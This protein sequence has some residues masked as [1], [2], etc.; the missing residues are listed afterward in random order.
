MITQEAAHYSIQSHRSK[1][2]DRLP[3]L[4]YLPRT[5]KPVMHRDL[6]LW[7]LISPVSNITQDTSHMW[8]HIPHIHCTYQLW[9]SQI[10]LFLLLKTLESWQ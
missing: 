4:C 1:R 8:S 9:N 7:E 3:C 6:Q 10:V 2:N 5:I